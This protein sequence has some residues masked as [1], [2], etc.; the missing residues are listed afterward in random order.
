MIKLA[1]EDVEQFDK[2]NNIARAQTATMTD[3]LAQFQRMQE[4]LSAA[5]QRFWKDLKERYHLEGEYRYEDGKLIAMPVPPSPEL[6]QLQQAEMQKPFV[7][8]VNPDHR[9]VLP[10]SY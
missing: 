10:P 5:S 2:L 9:A 7:D 8:D 6:T 1:P 4:H 3:F